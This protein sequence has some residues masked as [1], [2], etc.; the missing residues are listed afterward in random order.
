MLN[1][2]STSVARVLLLLFISLT[3]YT[4]SA[5]AIEPRATAAAQVQPNDF[6]L[7]DIKANS[8]PPKYLNCTKDNIG[9]SE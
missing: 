4:A 2:P 5:A 8:Q 9:D 6:V 1:K 3:Q 7:F